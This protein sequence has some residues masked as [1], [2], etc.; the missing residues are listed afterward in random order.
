MNLYPFQFRNPGQLLVDVLA[1][2]K[3]GDGDVL[4]A[5]VQHPDREQ[6]LLHVARLGRAV[7][8][9]TYDRS[10]LLYDAMQLMPIPPS[11]RDGPTVAVMTILARR[12]PAVIGA[13]EDEWAL[14]WR[15]SNHL[16]DA[17]TGDLMLVTEH[18]WTDWLTGLS[19][20]TPQLAPAPLPTPGSG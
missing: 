9:D 17:Y 6:R 4:L 11:R 12:G 8:D 15:Y 16:T 2:H 19:G 14:A 13:R 5:L 20:A 7:P 3:I 10:A 1:E 18:G